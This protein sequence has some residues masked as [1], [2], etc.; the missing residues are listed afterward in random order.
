MVNPLGATTV[1]SFRIGAKK[2]VVSRE[3]ERHKVS[4]LVYAHPQ[5]PLWQEKCAR[6]WIST[7]CKDCLHYVIVIIQTISMRQYFSQLL[8]YPILHCQVFYLT[9]GGALICFITSPFS[10]TKMSI[11][12]SGNLWKIIKKWLV[13]K[14]H[15]FKMVRLKIM[16][17]SVC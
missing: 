8:F 10:Y 5:F 2:L 1:A 3:Q 17:E 4:A 6:E 12:I 9:I 7:F 14:K 11:W 15:L 13:G 16:F